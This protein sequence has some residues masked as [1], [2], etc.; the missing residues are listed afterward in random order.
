MIGIGHLSRTIPRAKSSGSVL[1][2]VGADVEFHLRPTSHRWHPEYQRYIDL[3]RIPQTLCQFCIFYFIGIQIDLWDWS[4]PNP[5][6]HWTAQLTVRWR[7]TNVELNPSI[8]CVSG[9]TTAFFFLYKVIMLLVFVVENDMSEII[10]MDF[11]LHWRNR[12]DPV[13]P[14]LRMNQFLGE[15]EDAGGNAGWNLGGGLRAGQ[16]FW[17]MTTSQRVSSSS[18]RLSDN[19][20]TS[21]L[22]RRTLTKKLMKPK[23]SQI[24]SHVQS[25]SL[26]LIINTSRH[27][28]HSRSCKT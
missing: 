2:M 1:T 18:D 5:P 27:L 17:W 11:Y 22:I 3:W 16:S 8:Q 15:G 28:I 14:L 6:K 10:K 21:P 19:P 12:V 9:A 24:I 4:T 7:R 26:V 20:V 13:A 25:I 23:K